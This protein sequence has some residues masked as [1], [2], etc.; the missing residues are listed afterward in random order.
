MAQSS[1]PPSPSLYDEYPTFS[2]S[3][4]LKVA[5]VMIIMVIFFFFVGFLSVLIRRHSGGGLQG[6]RN[7]PPLGILGISGRVARGLDAAIIKSFPTFLYSKVKGIRIGQEA[8]ECS[9]CLNEFEDDET[10]RLIPT[11]SHVFHP[12]CIDA[13]LKFHDTCPVC[14]T[15]LAPKPSE[16]IS[17]NPVQNVDPPSETRPDEAE[18]QQISICV[19]DQSNVSNRVNVKNSFRSKSFGSTSRFGR[20]SRWF[21]RSHST[22]HSCEN[23]ERFTLRLPEEVRNQL[24][25]PS[26][27][28]TAMAFPRIRSTKKGYRTEKDGNWLRKNSFNCER[29][30]QEGK[31]EP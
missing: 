16:I 5:L 28:H 7:D 11:C 20:S 3:F 4:Y 25:N 13:W 14:R 30:D 26:L 17:I 27:N 1:S 12:D 15:N 24:V 18:N 22:G 23:Y 10:L 9:V 29:F 31:P 2:G 21:L 6:I 19:V 8:L